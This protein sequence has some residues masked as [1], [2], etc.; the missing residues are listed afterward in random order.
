MAEK[1]SMLGTTSNTTWMMSRQQFGT[2]ISSKYT[3]QPNKKCINKEDIE[4]NVL[5]SCAERG[6]FLDVT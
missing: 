6:H 1:K 4:D 3:G 2:D 5:E